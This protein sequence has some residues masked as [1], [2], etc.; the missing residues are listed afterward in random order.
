LSQED[1]ASRSG[2][3]VR[4]IRDIER[5]QVQRPRHSTV[6]LL[7]DALA[8]DE[9][10]QF[11]FKDAAVGSARGVPGTYLARSGIVP[12]QLPPDLE[13]FT[14][15]ELA[16]QKLRL[17]A[18]GCENTATAAMITAVVGKGGIGKSA[19]AV[20]AAHQLRSHFP[21]GQLYANLRGVEGRAIDPADVL[22]RFLSALGIECDRVPADVDSR[23]GLYRTLMADRRAIVVLDN[24]LREA[25]VRPLLPAGARNFVLVTSRARLTGLA[26]ADVVDLAALPPG[27]A[28][29][30]LRKT[31]GAD[32][33]ADEPEAAATIARLCGYLPLALRIVGVRL[34]AKPHWRLQRLVSRLQAHDRRLDELTAGDLEVRASVALSYQ[35]LGDLERRAFRVLGLL[36]VPDF[37]PSML[38]ALLDL[39]VT[40]AEDVAERLADAQLLDAIGEDAAGQLRYRC[41]DL[42]RLFAR[43]RLTADET[44][45]A[46][47]AVLELTLPRSFIEEHGDS[48]ELC[49]RP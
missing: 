16:L 11:A 29:E 2:M 6:S 35:G 22:G 25:Q 36:E 21:G 38:S 12:C 48:R 5:G 28:V 49:L 18:A 32:R 46:C 34:A 43:E 45:S 33:V 39:P 24:A 1:L 3:S 13:D 7:A 19:L 23:A 4:A 26:L 20:H 10:E 40:V 37:A 31:V 14:G 8:L 44:A 27:Q 15:H 41:H 47:G 17:R 30:L 42:L 9:S